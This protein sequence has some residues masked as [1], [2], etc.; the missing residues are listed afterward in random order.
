VSI[1]SRSE[2]ISYEAV[3]AQGTIWK[4][5]EQV[6]FSVEPLEIRR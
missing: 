6:R 1:S 2:R 5:G 4:T 3:V